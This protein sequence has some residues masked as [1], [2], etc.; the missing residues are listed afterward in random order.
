MGAL[1]EVDGIHGLLEVAA[2][3]DMAR[4]EPVF[5]QIVPDYRPDFA[6]QKGRE[7]YFN[8]S[9]NVFQKKAKYK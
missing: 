9:R 5:C 6:R 2:Y 3:T 4:L 7:K 1:A 8:F